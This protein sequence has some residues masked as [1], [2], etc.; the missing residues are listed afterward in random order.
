MESKTVSPPLDIDESMF[1]IDGLEL[2]TRVRERMGWTD[3]YLKS[4]NSPEHPLLKDI[5]QMSM[6]LEIL[7]TSDKEITI[8]PD[9]DTDGICA[10]MILYAGLNEIGLTTNLH[11][12]DYHLGHEIQPTVID[13][14][15]Q[16][17]PNTSAIITCDAGTNSTAALNHANDI[18]LIT[19]VTDHHVEEAKSLAHILVNPNRLDE[20]YPNREICGAHVA[21]QVVERYASLYRPGALSAITWLKTFAGIG[22]VADVM[23]LVYENRD[24]VRE[25]LMFTRLLTTTPEPAPTYKKVKSKYE[26][27]DEFDDIDITIDKTPTLLSMLRSQN[28][29]P[30]YMRAFEGLAMLLEELGTTH[31][32][33]DEQLYGF[34]IAPAFNA[35]R[36]VDGD[37]R[38]GFAVFTA[39]TPDEQRAAAQQ[40]VEYNVQ[41]KTQV[42]MILSEILESDQPWAPYVFPTDAL[43]GMLG[44]IAQNLMLMHGHP[45]AV[46]RI[47]ADGSC[48]GSMRS[49]TWFPVIEQLS[50][51]GDPNIGAQGHEFAC[52]VHAPSP[53]ALHDALATLVPKRR[54]EVIAETGILVHSDPAALVLGTSPDADAP[55]QEIKAIT[56]YMSAVKEL[57]PFGHGFP[58]P[59]VDMVINLVTCSIHT[60]G[61]QKQHL[62]IITPEGVALLWW[63]RSDLAPL[64][65]ERKS[66]IDPAD[67]VCR[68][69]VTLSLNTFA[70]R[71][72]LQGIVDHEVEIAPGS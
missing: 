70:G 29:H 10:G 22:T 1:E 30:V 38:T 4:I 69:R 5:D 20:T 58:A 62:K 65:N 54:D 24:L 68:L 23:G 43:P 50:S 3:Q 14:V 55:L 16:Q 71:T 46:V 45:V 27:P 18:G 57:A 59:P 6:A 21:Y 39:D 19:L 7:R 61:D 40:L 31:E 47:H 17:F 41:R 52:G 26:E 64:L 66:S 33:V 13:A 37:Y 53:Q 42:R 56:Q 67:T 32:R 49:P 28:H 34:S 8:V 60:M 72:T 44:L 36:R 15:R 51:L 63:N 11:I 12:P 35:T 25:A 9:F 2:F 48:S